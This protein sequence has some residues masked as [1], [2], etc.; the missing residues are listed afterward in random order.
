MLLVLLLLLF[1]LLLV[2][3]LF[4]DDDDDY[5]DFCFFLTVQHVQPRPGSVESPGA[6]KH[7]ADWLYAVTTGQSQNRCSWGGDHG[8][9]IAIKNQRIPWF[10]DYWEF[11]VADY[12]SI[13]VQLLSYFEPYKLD[14]L[15]DVALAIIC[16]AIEN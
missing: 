4:V 15:G 8:P 3:L 9:S 7:I 12:L 2:L 13:I 16:R 1:L 5:D 11:L 10:G 14:E 6:A